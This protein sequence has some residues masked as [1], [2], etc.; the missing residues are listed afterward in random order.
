[1]TYFF[2]Y[3]VWN[4]DSWLKEYAGKSLEE[5]NEMQEAEAANKENTDSGIERE[6]SKQ[7]KAVDAKND[8]LPAKQV[9][10]NPR[11]YF[12]IKIGKKN[13]KTVCYIMR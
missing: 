8:T 10:S 3:T 11:V 4:E 7:T 5:M 6:A 2:S 13:D 9:K 12:E 1:M